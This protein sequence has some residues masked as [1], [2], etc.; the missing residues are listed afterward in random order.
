M[1]SVNKAKISDTAIQSSKGKSGSPTQG[2][3]QRVAFLGPR[4]TNSELALREFV[5]SAEGIPCISIAEVF[6]SV[7]S[8]MV[9]A[10]LVPIDN[11]VQGPITE[12]LD[13][14]L[15]LVGKVY[16]ESSYLWDVRNGLGIL[17]SESNKDLENSITQIFSHAQ[18]LRQCANYIRKNFP[19][20]ELIATASTAAALR[21]VKEGSLT[22][23][24]VIA[25]PQTLDSEGLKVIKEDISDVHGNKTRFILIKP[26]KLPENDPNY[27]VVAGEAGDKLRNISKS[28]VTSF[29]IKPG[30]DRQGLLYEI[31]NVISIKNNINLVSIHSRPDTKGGFVFHL[32]IEGHKNDPPIRFCFEEL[33]RYCHEQ[34]GQTAEIGI[35]G[36]YR[37]NSFHARGI[38]RV[39]IIGGAGKMGAWFG[40]FLTDIGLEVR[41]ND[42]AGG[43]PLDRIVPSADLILISTPMSSIE[44]VTNALVP[45]LRKDQLVVE[46][47]SVKNSSIPFL[48][49]SLPKE[50]E[51]LGIHTMFGGDLNSLHGENVII[52]R[53]ARSGPKA[54]SF[55]DL[56]Y[57]YGAKLHHASSGEHDKIAAVVQ[58]ALQL[59]L[60]AYGESLS[61]SLGSSEDLDL[62]STP[63]FR[64]VFNSLIRVLRQD[65]QLIVDLQKL[66]SEG[67]HSRHSLL[68]ALFR[69]CTACDR[70]DYDEILKSTKRTREFLRGILDKRPD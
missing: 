21:T 56:L 2:A 48:E 11:L 49:K 47:C 67:T 8:G 28:Y 40:K 22:H 13:L 58:T 10:G 46:N 52:T 42:I 62:F 32:D 24:A 69:L 60:I 61:N 5:A 14:L 33:E 26:G 23:A 44:S 43:E 54:Q 27:T 68:E 57:K 34:T 53:T 12:T 59:L 16:I 25:P 55:E 64:S 15:E 6:C 30:K 39:A 45:F 65:D 37:R 3:S 29:V 1:S 9:N 66:N 50:V 38:E 35:F 63:N 18:P 4:G 70:G 19:R 17:K 7:A 20:A 36:S 31:L 51:L 41:M